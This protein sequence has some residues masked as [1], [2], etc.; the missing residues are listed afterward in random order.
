MPD[1]DKTAGRLW[2]WLTIGAGL[3]AVLGVAAWLVLPRLLDSDAVRHEIEARLSEALDREVTIETLD[4]DADETAVTLGRVRIADPPALGDGALLEAE[5]V[6]LDVGLDAL[7]H[8]AIEGT[9]SATGVNVRVVRVG[10]T[11]N[12]HGLGRGKPK[13]DRKP[14]P[15]ALAVELA[16]SRVELVDRDAGE[17]LTLD[18]VGLQA[19]VGA[20]AGEREAGVNLQIAEASLDALTLR[21]I[22]MQG[23]L[24][25]DGLSVSRVT[26]RLGEQ[27]RIAGSG[28]LALGPAGKPADWSVTASLSDAAIDAD[29]APIAVMV[30]PPLA[31]LDDAIEQSPDTE[32]GRLSL[33]VTLRGTG[34]TWPALRP[35]LV[36]EGSISLADVLIPPDT[37]VGRLAATAGHESGA[38]EL[39]R[40]TATFSLADEWVALDRVEAEGDVVVP[41]LRG[42]VAL[43]GRLDLEVD[44]M[45]LLKAYGGEAYE[46][47]S[48]ISSTIPIRIAGTVTDPDIQRPKASS[49]AK[50]LL[51]GLVNRVADPP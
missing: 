36:G 14:I 33:E 5:R 18:G 45:P 39:R 13:G 32:W 1:R 48:K 27:A 11:T 34:L 12:V 49:V 35:S 16:D 23:Q 20:D 24:E 19:V 37:L 51:G 10:Q 17:T 26:A 31:K 8:G 15:L 2:R 44:L 40:G 9:L 21:E 29:L 28:R 25:N 30:Y 7:R 3:I 6:R 47:A 4:V 38:L 41:P 22:A 50:G 43:D 46:R 42:R